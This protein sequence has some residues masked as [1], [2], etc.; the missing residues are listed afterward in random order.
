MCDVAE[1]C[2]GENLGCP[3][4]AYADDSTQCAEANEALAC[5]APEFCTGDSADCP[6]GSVLESD[7]IC[8]DAAG[9]CD[10]AEM[11]NGSDST[12]PDDETLA[13]GET[14]NDPGCAYTCNGADSGCPTSCMSDDDC[15]GTFTCDA[16]ICVPAI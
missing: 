12:C 13:D 9:P 15:I 3:E 6:S 1:T 2:D 14:P 5:D 8:R 7:A 16:M 11:C 4:N 10:V